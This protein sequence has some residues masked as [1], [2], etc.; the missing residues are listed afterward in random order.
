MKVFSPFTAR[1]RPVLSVTAILF[2]AMLLT[3]AQAASAGPRPN[4]VAGAAINVAE[5][6]VTTGSGS[7]GVTTAV[8]TFRALLGDPL[9]GATLGQQPAG[10]REINWDAVPAAHTNTDTFPPGFFNTNS[11]RG[12]ILATP[13]SGLRV[14]DNN[15]ADLNPTYAN[16]F[17]FFSPSKTFYPVGSNLTEVTFQTPG[18][19]TPASVRGFGVVFSDVDTFGAATLEYFWGSQSLGVFTVPTRSDAGGLSFLG[20]TFD[21]AVVTRVRITSGQAALGPGVNDISDNPYG[22][23]LAIVDDFLYGEPQALWS[24]FLPL[25]GR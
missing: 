11:T 19:T 8:T 6:T 15:F 18:A 4:R 16:Q 13:G 7:T 23:D 24:Q 10:R 5:P 2:T 12:A 1:L 21:S 22:Y 20:V 25:Q 14:S 9:N 3:R 17:A